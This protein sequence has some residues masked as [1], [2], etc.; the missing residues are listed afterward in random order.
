MRAF[1]ILLFSYMLSQFYRSF[2]AVIS[3]DLARDI[4]LDAAQLGSVS[5]AWFAAFAVAQFPV[6][7]ALDRFGPRWTLA[8]FSLAAVAGATLLSGATS[9]AGCLA[10]MALLGTGCAPALMASMY[11]F[12]RNHSVERFAMLSS[13]IIG[14]GTLGNL[15]GATPLALAV[16]SFG[17]RS[18]LL[19]V[20]A[21]TALSALLVAAFLRDPAPV[22]SSVGGHSVLRGLGRILRL[23]ALWP[24]LPITAVSYAVVIATRSL[25]ISPFLG[26]VYGLD[27]SE[28]GHAAFAM[29]LA[30]SIGALCYGPVQVALGT[31]TTT[32]IGVVGTALAFLAL[33]AWGSAS[34]SLAIALLTA[35]GA[36][37]MS[38]AVLIAHAREFIPTELL[39]RGVTY[40]NF[41]FIA[42][43]AIVQWCS[44]LFVQAA[45][46]AGLPPAATFGRLYLAF[47]ILLLAATCIYAFAPTR[48]GRSASQARRA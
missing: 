10:A 11:V 26:G 1:L 27:V 36:L 28:L 9:Y 25:W 40:M 23:R 48:T 43:A 22:Y 4:R 7:Y 13:A 18:S 12:A 17:W 41:A 30:M 37:G 8:G 31:K 20:A 15:A 5:A 32:T 3:V 33:G 24:I 47:G 2:L 6:G 21:S 42:G 29:G 34:L 35:A 44:G 38:Y 46:E 16:E 14:L 45:G 19:A 39:G